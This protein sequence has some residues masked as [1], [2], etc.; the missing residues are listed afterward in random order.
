MPSVPPRFIAALLFPA[1]LA[2]TAFAADTAP[3][4]KPSAADSVPVQVAVAERSTLPE[5]E[6]A[7]GTLVAWQE[8][9]V[10]FATAGN[11]MA[12]P[13]KPGQKVKAGDPMFQ[14]DDRVAKE[15]LMR[16]QSRAAAAQAALARAQELSR[17]G[18]VA[19]SQ[20]DSAVSD[21]ASAR[22]D[23]GTMATRL[24]L[25]T[26]RAP[27]DGVVG[28]INISPGAY[29]QPGQVLAEL[30]DERRLYVDVHVRQGLLPRLAPGLPFTV[31][32]DAFDRKVQGT[33]DYIDP[34]VTKD[35][36]SVRVRGIV[37][38]ADLSLR[39]GVA[40]RVDLQVGR[41]ENVVTVPNAALIPTMTGSDVYRLNGERVERVAVEL[42]VR[43]PQRTE[44]RSGLAAGD[45]VVT[46]GQFL[47][48]DGSPVRVTGEG[49]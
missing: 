35:D 42:G 36:R 13:L 32:S 12:I 47:L 10:A 39:D 2:G 41:R 43:G 14:L 27:F 30:E 5:V 48:K 26:L 40:V 24:D 4:A 7:F 33:V 9:D 22:A 29:V 34:R 25:L 28:L 1:L 45:R 11:V 23:L 44:I 38:N 6:S 17:T 46:V 20:L 31:T 19:R 16:A 21:D 37:E 8:V 49:S 15:D 18:N 3:P